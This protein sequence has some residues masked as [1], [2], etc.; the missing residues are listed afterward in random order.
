MSIDH[1]V[2]TA[3]KMESTVLIREAKD[4]HRSEREL[5]KYSS[6]P[7]LASARARKPDGK[8]DGEVCDDDRK[9]D[10]GRMLA[11]DRG[12][13]AVSVVAGNVARHRPTLPFTASS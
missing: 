6:G 9:V 4:G 2:D 10:H 8:D 3:L 12:G 7:T 1:S 13:E 11:D 5:R